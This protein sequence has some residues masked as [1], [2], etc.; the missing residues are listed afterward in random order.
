[1]S[2]G[3][4]G[5]RPVALVIGAAGMVGPAIARRLAAA[6][7]SVAPLTADAADGGSIADAV[8]GVA[9]EIG[10]IEVL[11]TGLGEAAPAEFTGLDGARWTQ[12]LNSHLRAV[13]NAC[14]AVLPGMVA[15]HRGMVVTLVPRAALPG[16]APSRPY[17]AAAGGTIIGFTKS[18]AVEMA[19]QGIRV[20]C[21]VAP[22]TGTGDAVADTV[23]FL[24]QEGDFYVG[25]VFTPVEGEGDKHGS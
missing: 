21:V 6:G 5:A 18:L 2:E 16:G 13:T 22:S 10:P 12:L 9:A 7:Y 1:M 20:N 24:A 25:Q 23:A 3:G 11:V 4:T 17:E 19:P 14:R 15:A 8:H